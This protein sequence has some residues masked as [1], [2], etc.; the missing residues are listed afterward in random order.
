MQK[1]TQ[2]F[3]QDNKL[4]DWRKTKDPWG[5]SLK[6]RPLPTPQD[7]CSHF[8]LVPP[9]EC[10]QTAFRSVN[11]QCTAI[12]DEQNCKLHGF[13]YAKLFCWTEWGVIILTQLFWTS[14]WRSDN[15]SRRRVAEVIRFL[16]LMNPISTFGLASCA[17]TD[18]VHLYILG[19][20]SKP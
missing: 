15:D 12:W 18:V 14:A 16:L 19:A 3:P 1:T 9:Q 7:L 8:I 10:E 5:P 6:W 13:P 20:Y 11:S 2:V 4:F 17:R